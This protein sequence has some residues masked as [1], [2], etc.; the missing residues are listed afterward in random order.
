[1]S[2]L[3]SFSLNAVLASQQM[4][5]IKSSPSWTPGLHLI[6]KPRARTQNRLHYQRISCAQCGLY[7]VSECF[8]IVITSGLSKG[9]VYGYAAYEQVSRGQMK[10]KQSFIG[11]IK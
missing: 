7:L 9:R 2:N 4:L 8:R 11:V 1:M 5:E 10:I 6:L 3:I